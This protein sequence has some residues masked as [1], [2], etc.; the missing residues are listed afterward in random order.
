MKKRRKITFC[1][2]HN[3]LLRI[4]LYISGKLKYF[5]V[6]EMFLYFRNYLF[7]YL[8]E[9]NAACGIYIRYCQMVVCY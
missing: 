8:S 5:R 4:I 2:K 9:V 3:Y 1:F 7:K 6:I